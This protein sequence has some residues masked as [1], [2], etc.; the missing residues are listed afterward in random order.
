MLLLPFVVDGV[1]T[2]KI[3]ADNMNII[4]GYITDDNIILQNEDVYGNIL[5]LNYSQN[6]Y[7][8]HFIECYCKNID[9]YDYRDKILCSFANYNDAIFQYN[10]L[11]ELWANPKIDSLEKYI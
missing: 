7:E 8:I 2:N 11:F 6:K 9:E 4:N 1:V 10:R 5:T 3:K